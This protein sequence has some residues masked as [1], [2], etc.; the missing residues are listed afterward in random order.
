MGDK[1]FKQILKDA[2]IGDVPFHTLR[3]T[4]GS[5]LLQES[6]DLKEVQTHLR[7]ARIET[8]A[9]VYAKVYKGKRRE[10]LTRIQEK[11]AI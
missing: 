10:S 2:G 8:T 1:W 6:G 5:L 3:K 4:S 7:Y 11:I 9:N